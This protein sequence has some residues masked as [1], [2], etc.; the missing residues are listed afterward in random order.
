M[1][2]FFNCE[3]TPVQDQDPLCKTFTNGVCTDCADRAFFNSRRVCEAVD[4]S[5]KDFT[6][7]GFFAFCT[8]C[9]EGFEVEGRRCV[10][11]DDDDIDPFCKSFRNG[12]CVECSFRYFRNSL[13]RC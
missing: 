12:V 1:N 5:C 9:Y 8:D 4:P 2:S 6:I 11:K 10:K 7:V 13:G 3:L